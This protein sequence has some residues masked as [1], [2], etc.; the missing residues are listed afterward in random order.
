MGE[1]RG[2][3]RSDLL[4]FCSFKG[5]ALLNKI[6]YYLRSIW[7]ILTGYQN[8][9]EVLS[10]V[11]GSD[12]NSPRQ[13][14]LKRSGLRYYV[15]SFMDAW[16]IKETCLDGDYDRFSSKVKDGW[17]VID[18]GAG[19]GDYSIWAAS[20]NPHGKV[21]A[22]EPFHQSMALLEKNLKLNAIGNVQVYAEAV[23][24]QAGSLHL[25]EVGAAVQHTTSAST[26]K[27]VTHE[28]KA[29]T[30]ATALE[31]L[32]GRACDLLKIDCEGAEYSILMKADP[33]C[34]GQIKQIVLEYHDQVTAYSHTDLRHFF[35]EMGYTVREVPNPVH[36]EIGF[37]H[38]N[39]MPATRSL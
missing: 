33:S 14:H 1:A 2:C 8:W 36:Q 20:Q 28:V 26:G 39:L 3:P 10:M 9:P 18:I 35:E 19:L 24:D 29:I 37:M 11:F 16:I 6:L 27:A 7:T 13:V 22:Y 5:V 34:W 15:R 32:D 12:K 23:S 4:L 25:E 21:F 30:L 17:M 38:V 31:R